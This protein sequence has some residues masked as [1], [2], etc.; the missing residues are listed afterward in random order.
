MV[1]KERSRVPLLFHKHLLK[2]ANRSVYVPFSEVP[3]MH[4]LARVA[5]RIERRFPKPGVA[6]SIP[7]AMCGV[8]VFAAQAACVSSSEAPYPAARAAPYT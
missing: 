7:V 2:K 8:I 6:G 5:Q 3:K 4:L 1:S